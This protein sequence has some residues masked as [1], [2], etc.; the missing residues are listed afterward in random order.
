[1]GKK[2][3]VLD[4]DF[5]LNLLTNTSVEFFIQ[6]MDELEVSP[7]VHSYVADVELE[8]CQEAQELIKEG[9]I[10]KIEYAEYLKTEMQRDNYNQAVWFI[11][12][13]FNDGILPPLRYRNVFRDDF[14][15][16][17]HSIGEVLSE[18]MAKEL[19]FELFAS[20]DFGAKIIANRHINSTYYKLKVW[21]LADVFKEIGKRENSLQWKDIKSALR[22]E[23]WKRDKKKLREFWIQDE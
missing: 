6:L 22:D 2:E 8:Y 3:A 15:Y 11:L 23:R 4:C 7:V 18:L 1:M 21:N 14:S 5:L 12:D 9:Y 10:R 19:K 20:N 13:I 16:K 17:T